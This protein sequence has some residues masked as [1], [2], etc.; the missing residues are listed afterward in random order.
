MMKSSSLVSV[1]VARTYNL[2]ASLSIKK[3]HSY[4]GFGREQGIPG[5]AFTEI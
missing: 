1:Q 5:L 3:Q 2:M 4:I